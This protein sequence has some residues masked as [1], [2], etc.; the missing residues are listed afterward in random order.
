MS[1]PAA[2]GTSLATLCATLALTA[3][4]IKPQ[5]RSGGYEPAAGSDP[6]AGMAASSPSAASSPA[7]ATPAAPAVVSVTLRNSCRDT[8]KVFYGDKP[9]FGSGTYS[10]LSSNSVTSKQFR[11]GDMIWIVDDSQQGLAS[12]TISA[13]MNTVEVTSGCTG[14]TSH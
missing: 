7:P 6:A 4:L 13:G 5:P 12:A 8:V 11:A 10:T 14:L 1:I 2:T 3:C 9:K